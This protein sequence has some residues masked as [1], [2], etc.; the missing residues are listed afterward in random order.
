M[1]IRLWIVNR[2][3]LIAI[4]TVAFFPAA[5]LFASVDSLLNEANGRFTINEKPIHPGLFQEFAIWL[6]DNSNPVTV[7]VDVLAGAKARNEY[8]AD[9]VKVQDGYISYSRDNGESFSYKWLGRLSNGLHVVEVADSGGGSGVFSDLF[10]IRFDKGEGWDNDGKKY[11]RLLM[12]VVRTFALGD[13]DDGEIKVLPDQVIVG[14]SK[15]RNEEAV[16]K[17]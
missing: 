3:S 10:F 9:A 17:F 7:T 5:D 6:S 12:T 14:K 1:P 8:D 11:D 4:L 13:R 16:M 15:Y 2:I